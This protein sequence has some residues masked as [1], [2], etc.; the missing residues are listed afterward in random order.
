MSKVFKT[1]S[2]GDDLEEIAQV[3]KYKGKG[4]A[5]TTLY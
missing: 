1:L 4:K 5:D 3:I 2:K